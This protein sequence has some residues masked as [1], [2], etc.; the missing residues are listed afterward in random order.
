LQPGTPEYEAAFDS[1]AAGQQESKR[2]ASLEQR[3]VDGQAAVDKKNGWRKRLVSW[4]ETAKDGDTITTDIEGEEYLVVEKT[5]K[6]NGKE[7]VSKR[8]VL[9]GN[10]VSNDQ[11]IIEYRDGKAYTGPNTSQGIDEF[12]GWAQAPETDID[13]RAASLG[14]LLEEGIAKVGAGGT[15]L[16]AAAH[17]AAT[18]PLNDLP[19]PTE[20]QK[21]AGNYAKGHVRFQGMDISIENP[22]GSVRSGK[23]EDGKAWE[24]TLQHHYGY[25]KGTIGRDKDHLDVF[26]KPGAQSART[27][28]VVDQI[29]PKTGKFDEHKIVLGADSEADARAIYQANYA[30]GWNGLGEITAMPIATFKGWIKSGKTKRPIAYVEPKGIAH[31]K[32][33]AKPEAPAVIDPA[34][35]YGKVGIA[36]FSSQV[37]GLKDNGDGTAT[38]MR[39]EEPFY[40]FENGDTITV[41]TDATAGRIRQAVT[42][43]GALSSRDK[44]FGVAKVGTK[45]AETGT[46]PAKSGTEP[47]KLPEQDPAAGADF[48]ASNRAEFRHEGFRIYPISIK[49]EPRWAVQ[50]LD[51]S[52]RENK[53]ERQIGGDAIVDTPEQAKQQAESQVTERGQKAERQRQFAEQDA[54]EEAK[55][56]ANRGLSI[57]QRRAN[58]AL[59]KPTNLPVNAG[60]GIGTRREAMESAVSQE[61]AITAV[62][63]RDTAA[64]KRDEDEQG[65]LHR[66]GY[67]AFFGNDSHPQKMRFN[68]LTAKLKNRDNYQKKEYRLYSGRDTDGG[69]YEITKTEYDYA[70]SLMTD[71]SNAKH[72]AAIAGKPV[73]DMPAEQLQKIASGESKT[74]GPAAVEKASAELARR[75]EADS[76]KAT[77]EP[78]QYGEL[79]YGDR[80]IDEVVLPDL[81]KQLANAHGGKFQEYPSK[82]AAV[83]GLKERIDTLENHRDAKG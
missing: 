3:R 49:G 12:A 30:E 51:N 39:G 25:I 66:S 60:V 7:I 78:W 75:D 62:D 81:R 26:I 13:S 74:F 42:D 22:A 80:Y 16:D 61:R 35:P 20:A 76:P 33:S 36:P 64:Y 57:T 31:P 73:A 38:V 53:G 32:P 77:K 55:K 34:A 1:W 70:K 45:P 67:G 8:L 37:V 21:Q 54:A 28:Y 9:V 79:E 83:R 18:S 48:L 65:R 68:E 19:Q 72:V 41:P 44:W 24:N 52:E 56:E 14:K 2:S 40:D 46:E 10:D 82:A 50:S 17:Q 4:F 43:A 63:V 47:T 23:D 69:F 71:S 29:N 58:A 5:I 11:T 6:R 27:A 59:D 15:A